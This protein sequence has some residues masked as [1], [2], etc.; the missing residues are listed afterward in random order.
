MSLFRNEARKEHSS[1]LSTA[2]VAA[3]REAQATRPMDDE[4]AQ[5]AAAHTAA[6]VED[7]VVV[8]R[9]K[10]DE[11]GEERARTPANDRSERLTALFNAEVA[12]GFKTR[13]DATQIG[14]VDDPRR[15]VQQ[16]DELVAEVM[17]SLAQRFADERTQLEAQMKSESASTESLRVALQRYRSFLQR[18]LSL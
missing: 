8:T 11:R 2:D 6:E 14:F 18:L 17:Q 7:A 12:Q 9:E 1:R 4:R 10:R 15:A 3:A 16:A 5:V 13:W